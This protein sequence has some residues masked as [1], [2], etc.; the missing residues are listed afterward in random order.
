MLCAHLRCTVLFGV[1][2][3]PATRVSISAASGLS[4]CSVHG[5]QL[6][7]ALCRA[8][9]FEDSDSDSGPAPEPA[10][11]EQSGAAGY[12]D[13]QND[14]PTE[15][16]TVVEKAAPSGDKP[17]CAAVRFL[18]SNSGIA[19]FS[20]FHSGSRM[21]LPFLSFGYMHFSMPTGLWLLFRFYPSPRV[22]F[23][24]PLVQTSGLRDGIG[25]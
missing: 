6:P 5:E 24:C 18:I 22:A 21:D 4:A 3:S 15:R 12:P 13:W 9:H 16:P 23:W 1:A 11:S 8:P 14:G 7:K 2:G 10:S 17:A 20:V 19:H 25:W